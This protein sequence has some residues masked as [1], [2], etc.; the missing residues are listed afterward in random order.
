MKKHIFNYLNYFS[1]LIKVLFFISISLPSISEENQ[2]GLVSEIN[3]D[4]IAIN[5]NLDERELSIF[6]PI[7]SNEE[8]FATQNS[9]LVLQFNDNTSIIMKELTTL[10]VSEFKNSKLNMNIWKIQFA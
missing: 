8:I 9:S 6:D 5:N 4:A 7:F 10:N 3:G 2:I 1:F